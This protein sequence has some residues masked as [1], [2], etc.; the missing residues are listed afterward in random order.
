MNVIFLIIICTCALGFLVIN[1]DGFLSALLGGASKS[2]SLCL[3]LLATYAVWMGLMQVCEDSGVSP[4]FSR[5]LRPIAAKIFK[6]KDEQALNA[7]CMNLS[8]N[9]LGISGAATPYGIQAAHLLD[10][11]EHPEYASALFLILNATS[12]QLFPSSI[13]AVRTSLHSANPTAVVLPCILASL[14]ATLLAV[15]IFLLCNAI[16]HPVKKLFSAKISIKNQKM[17]GAGTR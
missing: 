2:A 9:L 12:L 16:H 1:P 3:A 15:G 14:F 10:K 8:V 5:R 17:K 7:V 11:T 6:T 13:V 4:A